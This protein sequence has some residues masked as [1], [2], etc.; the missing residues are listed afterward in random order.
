[1]SEHLDFGGCKFFHGITLIGIICST[2][3]TL[4]FVSDWQTALLALPFCFLCW[5]DNV[6]FLEEKLYGL[7][8]DGENYVAVSARSQAN[9]PAA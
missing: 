3:F 5:S 4:L 7:I 2:W 6:S 9:T 1:M 8:K